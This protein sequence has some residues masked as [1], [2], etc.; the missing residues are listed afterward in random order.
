MTYDLCP[1]DLSDKSNE[2]EPKRSRRFASAIG[3]KK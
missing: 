1:P 2:P 3:L